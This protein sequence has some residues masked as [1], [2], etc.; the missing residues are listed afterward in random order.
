[1]C[2]ITEHL[3]AWCG[4][5]CVDVLAQPA[6]VLGSPRVLRRAER[7]GVLLQVVCC[8]HFSAPRLACNNSSR[9]AVEQ[10]RRNERARQEPA[11]N[12][13]PSMCQH[14]RCWSLLAVSHSRSPHARPL[15]RMSRSRPARQQGGAEG[16][17]CMHALARMSCGVQGFC[18]CRVTCTVACPGG[19]STSR[20]SSSNKCLFTHTITDSSWSTTR[21]SQLRIELTCA[22]QPHTPNHGL[23]ECRH[24]DGFVSARADHV[25]S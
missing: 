18:N 20:T 25:F 19:I 24:Y 15:P 5:R 3:S 16:P 1:V 9:S 22:Q 4:L 14:P 7:S 23:V 17:A 6:Q 13:V 21:Q 12:A 8:L 11:C 10:R 2:W